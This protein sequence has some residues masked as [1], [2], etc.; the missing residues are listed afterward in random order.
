MPSFINNFGILKQTVQREVEDPAWIDIFLYELEKTSAWR[1]SIVTE[2][3]GRKCN[4]CYV[5]RLVLGTEKLDTAFSKRLDIIVWDQD[6]PRILRSSCE[7][8][9]PISTMQNRNCSRSFQ[10]VQRTLVIG[11]KPM[12]PTSVKSGKETSLKCQ[13]I[14]ISDRTLQLCRLW[15]G[16][17]VLHQLVKLLPEHSATFEGV[18]NYVENIAA[19]LAWL[20]AFTTTKFFCFLNDAAYSVGDYHQHLYHETIRPFVFNA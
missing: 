3:Y 6:T 12:L 4:N 16:V 15:I 20:D 14:P 9:G 5:T 18:H 10:K 7:Q 11:G 1:L 19:N 17:C 8:M 2:I 13:S